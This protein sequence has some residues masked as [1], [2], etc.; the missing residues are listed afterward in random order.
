MY[1]KG[2]T[3]VVDLIPE[4]TVLA[5]PVEKVFEVKGVEVASLLLKA[6]GA[7]TN[8]ITVKLESSDNQVDFYSLINVEDTAGVSTVTKKVWE[9]TMTDSSD[10]I[11]IPLNLQNV[12]LKLTV[13]SSNTSGTVGVKMVRVE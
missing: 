1:R 6:T 7:S 12:F 9:F 10:N 11:E 8:K 2:I 3:Q 4:G 13:S 5:T